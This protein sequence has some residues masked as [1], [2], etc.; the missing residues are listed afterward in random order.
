MKVRKPLVTIQSMCV[1]QVIFLSNG[2][3]G[4]PSPVFIPVEDPFSGPLS[5][6]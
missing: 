5:A 6:F 4:Q 1:F 2:Y 3:G